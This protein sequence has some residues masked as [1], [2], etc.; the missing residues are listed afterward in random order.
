VAFA[1][2]DAKFRKYANGGLKSNAG[3]FLAPPS[4]FRMRMRNWMFSVPVLFSV[5]MKVTDKFATDIEL[6]EYG[7]EFQ[8]G[9]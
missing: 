4:R 6:E 2:Y 7:L 8:R 3:P 5:L 1:Q 9:H